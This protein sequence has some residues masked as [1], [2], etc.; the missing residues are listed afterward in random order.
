MSW[1]RPFTRDLAHGAQVDRLG[2][3]D[4]RSLASLTYPLRLDPL[5]GGKQ[6][7]FN[8]NAFPVLKVHQVADAAQLAG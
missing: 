8:A 7:L 2:A 1:T 3:L 6:R 5:A 4:A